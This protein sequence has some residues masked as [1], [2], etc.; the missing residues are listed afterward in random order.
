MNSFYDSCH[1][2]NSVNEILQKKSPNTFLRLLCSD[3]DLWHGNGDRGEGIVYTMFHNS[4]SWF[5][6]V[7]SNNI[8]MWLLYSAIFLLL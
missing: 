3:C 4:L 5:G 2:Q 8:A 6:M 7:Y 1:L